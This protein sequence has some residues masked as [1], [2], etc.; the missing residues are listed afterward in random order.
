MVDI[1][2]WVAVVLLAVGIVPVAVEPVAVVSV[3]VDENLAVVATYSRHL[4][5][6]STGGSIGVSLFFLIQSFKCQTAGLN[7]TVTKLLKTPRH[8]APF[9]PYHPPCPP[10]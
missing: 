8:A 3:V 4:G 1:V 5:Q 9:V 10:P 6:L 2:V 7:K